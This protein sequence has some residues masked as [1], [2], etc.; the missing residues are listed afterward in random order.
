MTIQRSLSVSPLA[1]IPALSRSLVAV[2]EDNPRRVFH[3]TSCAGSDCA[4]LQALS[5]ACQAMS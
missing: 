4:D 1:A 3:A 2:E 5:D